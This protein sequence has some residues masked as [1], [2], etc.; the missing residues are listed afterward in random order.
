MFGTLILPQRPDQRLA[1]E[2]WE[3]DFAPDSLSR[4]DDDS[5]RSLKQ[6]M[7][8]ISS[9][10]TLG[11]VLTY[12]IIIIWVV[13]RRGDIWFAI[14]ELVLNDM[15][16]GRPKHQT[17]ELTST[18]PKLGHPALVNCARARVAGE[19]YFDTGD[20]P[21]VWKIS[22]NS[23]RYGRLPSRTRAHLNNVADHF[24]SFRIDLTPHF[25]DP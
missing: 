1:V 25:I 9:G 6:T 22:N 23:G 13:D 4:L 2:Q 15:P 3:R 5:A 10:W 18:F 14:E 11:R 19:I 17:L 16:T 21:P 20:D 12:D 8:E 24:R 7:E